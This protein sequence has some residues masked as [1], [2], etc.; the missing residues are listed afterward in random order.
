MLRGRRSYFGSV[1]ISAMT[2][3]PATISPLVSEENF[4]YVKDVPAAGS[5]ALLDHATDIPTARFS[6]NS[7]SMATGCAGSV[8]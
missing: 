2:L 6:P 8:P 3:K 7:R 1:L 4:G 5:L